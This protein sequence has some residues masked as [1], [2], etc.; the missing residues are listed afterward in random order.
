MRGAA[1]PLGS[2]LI[3][4]VFI[5][6]VPATTVVAAAAEV[7]QQKAGITISPPIQKLTLGPG[8]SEANTYIDVTNTTDHAFTASIVLVDFKS[9]SEN[10][11]LTLGQVNVPLWKYGLANWMQI[12]G[13][14]RLSLAPGETRRVAVTI[15]N[16]DD[17]IPGGHY[18]A[19]IFAG[20]SKGTTSLDE[21]QIGFSQ[22]LA[23]LLFVK[24][25]GGE[26][27]GLTVSSVTID[28]KHELPESVSIDFHSTGN[29]YVIPRGYIEVIDS[30]GTLVE[31]GTINESSIIIMQ[32]NSQHFI[33]LLRPTA[34]SNANGQFKLVVHYRYAGQ[35]DYQT[36]TIMFTRGQGSPVGLIAGLVTGIGALV[37]ASR[38][39]V[40]RRHANSPRT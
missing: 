28:R 25:L 15:Q 19:V 4:S 3:A 24:K 32:G 9:L 7:V 18:G 30:R 27:Y 31:R 11:G 13:D 20:D 10:G 17:L 16:R 33:T 8:L 14:P 5:A 36:Q 22:N 6:I 34:E 38:I 40:R 35:A 23:S 29:V 37:L 21:N 39:V 1:K 26:K 2:V 12:T